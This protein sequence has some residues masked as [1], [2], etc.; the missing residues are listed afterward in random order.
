MVAPVLSAGAAD[1]LALEKL[2]ARG[3]KCPAVRAPPRSRTCCPHHYTIFVPEH[4]QDGFHASAPTGLLSFKIVDHR[5][6]YSSPQPLASRQI[7]EDPFKCSV[8]T[9][10][11]VVPQLRRL[12]EPTLSGR[13]H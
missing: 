10:L 9:V 2:L 7:E 11:I 13:R 3:G 6:L 5:T 8:T 1:T 12:D 4:R